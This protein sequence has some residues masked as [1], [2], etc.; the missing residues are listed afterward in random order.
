[1]AKGMARDYKEFILAVEPNQNM[2]DYRVYIRLIS[3]GKT[4]RRVSDYSRFFSQIQITLVED[5][6]MIDV[7]YSEVQDLLKTLKRF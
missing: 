6:E 4:R 2:S 1:M 3:S 5:G 7:H